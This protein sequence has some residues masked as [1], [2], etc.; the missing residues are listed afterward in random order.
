MRPPVV[1]WF[2]ARRTLSGN[3]YHRSLDRLLLPAVQAAREAARRTQCLN[4]IRQL[5]LCCH[6]YCDAKKELPAGGNTTNQ[7]S[8]LCYILPQ[9][10]ESAMYDQMQAGNA[11]EAGTVDGGTDFEG[12]DNGG[13]SATSGQLHRAQYFAKVKLPLIQCP[14]SSSLLAD[15]PSARLT[16][17]SGNKVPTYQ[18]HY[19][20]VA[21]PVTAGGRT[22]RK[23]DK[24]ANDNRG[25]SSD[26]GLME[27]GYGVRLRQVTDGLSKTLML[28]EL[29]HDIF[30]DEYRIRL[31]S[32]RE[33]L[34]LVPAVPSTTALQ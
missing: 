31:D 6:M 19:L 14:S 23:N 22:Y 18:L 2:Y 33:V 34:A 12:F 1:G 15:K 17:P 24:C 11:F 8:W 13:T 29:N 26:Q 4:Q 3:C 20:G 21:G 25:G 10:E 5:A 27:F 32:W 16:D 28:G 9:M 30:A 7:L